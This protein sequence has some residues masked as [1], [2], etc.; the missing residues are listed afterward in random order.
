MSAP[1]IDV[2]WLDVGSFFAARARRAH[3]ARPELAG[4]PGALNAVLRFFSERS[5]TKKGVDN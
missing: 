5:A 1:V 4:K 2:V 3:R